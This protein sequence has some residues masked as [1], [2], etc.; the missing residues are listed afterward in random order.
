[1]TVVE[2]PTTGRS[3]Q[4]MS[5]VLRF[6]VAMTMLATTLGCSSSSRDRGR[7]RVAGSVAFEGTPLDHGSVLFARIGDRDVASAPVRPGGRFTVS[8]LP[9]DYDIAVRCVASATTAEPAMD[10]SEPKS[11]IP[12]KYADAK[13]SGLKVIAAPGMPPIT[14]DLAR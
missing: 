14:L 7:I 5:N 8:L 3:R 1:M 13:A 9:G 2:S 6:V 10:W 12:E 4:I 11:L